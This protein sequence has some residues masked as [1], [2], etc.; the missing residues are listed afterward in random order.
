MRACYVIYI[1]GISLPRPSGPITLRLP[2]KTVVDC[3]HNVFKAEK[4][5]YCSQCFVECLK[6]YGKHRNPCQ[7]KLS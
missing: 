5:L 6:Q 3:F 2:D 4:K 1:Q 7:I